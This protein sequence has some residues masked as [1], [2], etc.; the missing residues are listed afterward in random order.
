M[1]REIFE[2]SE[3]TYNRKVCEAKR[4]IFE[5][6]GREATEKEIEDYLCTD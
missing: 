5:H 1:L 2:P 6:K 4:A 3:E